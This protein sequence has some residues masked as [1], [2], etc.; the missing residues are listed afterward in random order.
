MCER[1][2]G[3]LHGSRMESKLKN[4]CKR[5]FRGETLDL[6][7]G[8]TLDGALQAARL[9][10]ETIVVWVDETVSMTGRKVGSCVG[11]VISVCTC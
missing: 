1:H 8:G 9:E 7:A 5:V 3:V 11:H 6:F 4:V 2:F 10:T